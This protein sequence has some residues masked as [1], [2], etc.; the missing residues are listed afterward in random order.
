M[1][2]GRRPDCASAS[3]WAKIEKARS[4]KEQEEESK[5]Y[6]QAR[7][8]RVVRRPLLDQPRDGFSIW[9]QTCPQCGKEVWKEQLSEAE[10]CTCGWVWEGSVA[11]S[12]APTQEPH[13][14][15]GSA[16][17]LTLQELLWPT[18]CEH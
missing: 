17:A 8:R 12:D 4:Q 7:P 18:R 13:L 15:S 11:P 9:T 14:A 1:R 16:P 6:P 5:R 3:Y 2:R 10:P